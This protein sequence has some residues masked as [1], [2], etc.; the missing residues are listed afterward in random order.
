MKR[1]LV[2]GAGSFVGLHCVKL[3]LEQGYHVRGTLRDSG[4]EAQLRRTLGKHGVDDSRLEFVRADLIDDAGW[5]RAVDGCPFV[6]HVASPY[7]LYPPKDP[8]AEVIGP[9]V[10]G[11]LRVLRACALAGVE[12]VVLTS[13]TAAISL[14]HP[15]E[16]THFDENDWSKVAGDFG[17]YGA[18]KTLA[19]RAAWDFVESQTGGRPVELVVLHP[20][21]IYGPLLERHYSTSMELVRVLVGRKTPGVARLM[22]E[23]SDVRDVAAAHLAA[24]VVPEAAG[25]RFPIVGASAWIE[26]VAM[27][28]DEHFAVRG[29]RIPTRLLPDR[30]VRFIALFNRSVRLTVP[31]LGRQT[32]TSSDQARRILGWDPRPKEEAIVSLAEGLL[33]YGLVR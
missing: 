9:A 17:G 28:L 13:S 16:K 8:Q 10:E 25:K 4:R 23:F 1:V 14:G 24:L 27:I 19:E 21:F 20:P 30:L 11:T 3:L 12:R 18:S 32:F 7:P 31:Y 15:P 26:E 22:V 29:R 5:T 33:E 2:T 6:L